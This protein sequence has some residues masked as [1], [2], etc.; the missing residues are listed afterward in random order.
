MQVRISP[1]PQSKIVGNAKHIGLHVEIPAVTCP[2]LAIAAITDINRMLFGD[3]D[4]GTEA[5]NTPIPSI[6]SKSSKSSLSSRSSMS[7][8]S[9]TFSEIPTTP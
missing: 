1:N 3:E 5:K 4:I 2:V 7:P 9:I 6:S 8:N